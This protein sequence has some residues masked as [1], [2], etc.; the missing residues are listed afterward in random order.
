M[1]GFQKL[2]CLSL[3]RT[4]AR[5]VIAGTVAAWLEV[6]S[7]RTYEQKRD[8]PRIRSAFMKLAEERREWPAPADFLAAMPR[9]T[10]QATARP[11]T[12]QQQ[13]RSNDA[14]CTRGLVQTSVILGEMRLTY[15]PKGKENA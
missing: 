5:D 7:R 10:S 9:A 12:L 15:E 13:R 14:H 3:D 6:L 11:Q 4:P 2:L 1:T 8:T